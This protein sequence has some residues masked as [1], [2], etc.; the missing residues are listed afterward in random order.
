MPG[1]R[2]PLCGIYSKDDVEANE[3]MELHQNIPSTQCVICHRDYPRRAALTHHMRIHV[4][5]K[6]LITLI[7]FLVI[8]SYNIFKFQTRSALF[9]CEKCGKGFIHRT[10][11]EA[12]IMAHEDLR[13]KICPHCPRKFRSSSHLIRH[14][15]IHVT[16]LIYIEHTS[17]DVNLFFAF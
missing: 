1:N 17:F 14:M 6:L 12:H 3:H 4:S 2:C 15:R 7:T 13:D 10:S 11:F 16:L 9:Q 8:Y 5:I